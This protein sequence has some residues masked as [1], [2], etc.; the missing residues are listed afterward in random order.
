MVA[1]KVRGKQCLVIFVMLNNISY[2]LLICI[3][4]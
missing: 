4:E 2:M 3:E 1:Q